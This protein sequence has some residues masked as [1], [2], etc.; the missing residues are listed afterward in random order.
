[1]SDDTLYAAFVNGIRVYNGLKVLQYTDAGLPILGWES[2]GFL[3]PLDVA[4]G[5]WHIVNAY[6]DS[7]PMKRGRR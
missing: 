1:M 3:D 5:K 2:G 7:P 4:Q 6:G